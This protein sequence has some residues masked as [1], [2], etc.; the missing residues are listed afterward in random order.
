M[1]FTTSPFLRRTYKPGACESMAI[2][3]CFTVI[4]REVLKVLRYFFVPSSVMEQLACV[5]ARQSL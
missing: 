2:P 3:P 1:N 4:L 5:Q